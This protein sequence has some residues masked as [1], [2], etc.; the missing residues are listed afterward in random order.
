[1]GIRKYTD[2][3]RRERKKLHQKSYYERKKL[4]DPAFLDQL[5]E[6]QR[7]R[8]NR[9]RES[10]IHIE[11][12]RKHA[13]KDYYERIKP[14][15][16][17]L[18]KRRLQ[19]KVCQQNRRVKNQQTK[20]QLQQ[21]IGGRCVDCGI[22]DS[23]LLDFD[24]RDPLTK[25]MMISQKLYLPFEVLLN[26]AQKCDLRCPNCH[27]IKTQNNKEYDAYKYREYRNSFR[28]QFK[29]LITHNTN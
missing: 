6:K 23:R 28:S 7:I 3:Q 9:N 26:E 2:E 29:P 12:H 15:P 20:V 16:E 24:H 13:L 11:R 5:A 4:S 21:S 19:V 22:T 1:M 27:R 14:N 25:T 10:P 17:L 18:D 8:Y